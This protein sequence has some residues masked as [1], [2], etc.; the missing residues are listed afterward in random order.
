MVI[1]PSGT[2]YGKSPEEDLKFFRE[3]FSEIT[4]MCYTK[5]LEG[6]KGKNFFLAKTSMLMGD[7]LRPTSLGVNL[8][9]HLEV[10]RKM[11]QD[12]EWAISVRK[13]AA[14]ISEDYSIIFHEATT[15]DRMVAM[16]L[17]IKEI[18]EK[19]K[20]DYKHNRS[21]IEDAI[22][23]LNKKS[24][25]SD[26]DKV[27]SQL[28]YVHE[29]DPEALMKKDVL[30][31]LIEICDKIGIK[32]VVGILFDKALDHKD[33]NQ[34]LKTIDIH[35]KRMDFWAELDD[36]SCQKQEANSSAM[37][38]ETYTAQA[39]QKGN[40]QKQEGR[41]ERYPFKKSFE[42][43][44]NYGRTYNQF[45]SNRNYKGN[46]YR[47]RYE[48]RS[49]WIPYDKRNTPEWKPPGINTQS[50]PLNNQDNRD[51]QRSFRPKY[52][53]QYNKSHYNCNRVQLIVDSGSE[54]NVFG[55]EK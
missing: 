4:T 21:M 42:H 43:K 22:K 9:K 51:A 28:L 48:R 14:Q 44:R 29:I 18:I 47:K 38:I 7:K 41:F 2:Q 30:K 6:E 10:T 12:T 32:D 19:V 39:E 33:K 34:Y 27:T 52:R 11:M 50:Q 3:L 55:R 45:P 49:D 35:F 26:V 40:F 15:C 5:S 36:K 31:M 24:T 8:K 37:E 16:V 20:V 46:D 54:A 1:L 23:K 53:G 17:H 25:R 13:D